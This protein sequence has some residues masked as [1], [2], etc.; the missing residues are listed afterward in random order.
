MG[1]SW[2][3]AFFVAMRLA[4]PANTRPFWG[5]RNISR[6]HSL[7]AALQYGIIGLIEVR[8][9]LTIVKTKDFSCKTKFFSFTL[10]YNSYCYE[11]T[12]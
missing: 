1:V 4:G 6:P 7:R 8:N 10:R 9:L 3:H 11:K 12:Y 5:D 2:L